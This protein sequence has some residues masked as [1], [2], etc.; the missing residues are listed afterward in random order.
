MI[1]KIF[2]QPA[3]DNTAE[4]TANSISEGLIHKNQKGSYLYYFKY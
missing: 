4:M 2:Q 1:L 3:Y